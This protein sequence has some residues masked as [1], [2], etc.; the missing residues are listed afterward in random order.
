MRIMS[1]H[2]DELSLCNMSRYRYERCPDFKHRWGHS[3]PRNFTVPGD[4]FCPKTGQANVLLEIRGISRRAG[5]LFRRLVLRCLSLA[6]PEPSGP[7]DPWRLVMPGPFN[8]LNLLS[9]RY[10]SV[11]RSV[12]DYVGGPKD[13]E[14]L[15]AEDFSFPE[16]H[17]DGEYRLTGVAWGSWCGGL[18]AR[19]PSADPAV[20]IWHPRTESW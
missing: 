13:N 11:M 8:L 5:S 17:P 6:R 9:G 10:S 4:F 20:A 14:S 3:F 16:V 12:F 15:R 1:R 7:C 2:S 18:D 19:F